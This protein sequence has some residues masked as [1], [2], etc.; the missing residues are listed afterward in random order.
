MKTKTKFA[1]ITICLL[2][3]MI[4]FVGCSND[5]D[6]KDE[7]S[8]WPYGPS[9]TWITDEAEGC[10]LFEVDYI[11]N[12]PEIYAV[13]KVLERPKH[14]HIM[15]DKTVLALKEELPEAIKKKD[16]LSMRVK[17]YKWYEVYDGPF[18]LDTSKF[19]RMWIEVS[20]EPCE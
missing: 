18:I 3:L 15:T 16:R 8:S 20:V 1:T 7:N 11:C 14:G 13:L 19:S 6:N 5:E 4:G 17:K 10:Y 2:L 12:P 9:N